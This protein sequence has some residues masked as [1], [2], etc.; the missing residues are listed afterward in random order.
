MGYFSNMD[1][2][3]KEGVRDRETLTNDDLRCEMTLIIIQAYPERKYTE[4]ISLGDESLR[5]LYGRAKRKLK[6]QSSIKD[7][8]FEEIEEERT[9]RR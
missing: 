7:Y 1:V 3:N 9:S 5:G 4:V 8:E 2:I 6:T